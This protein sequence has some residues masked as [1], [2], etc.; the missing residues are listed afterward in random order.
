[1]RHYLSIVL[2]ALLAACAGPQGPSGPS[3]AQQQMNY[4]GPTC[5]PGEVVYNSPAILPIAITAVRETLAVMNEIG[6]RHRG[7]G[8]KPRADQ[9]AIMSATTDWIAQAAYAGQIETFEGHAYA[10]I[11]IH[12]VHPL[13]SQLPY[14]GGDNICRGMAQVTKIADGVYQVQIPLDGGEW[15]GRVGLAVPRAA[16]ITDHQR[17]WVCVGITGGYHLAYQPPL[18]EGPYKDEP[19][20]VCGLP[21]PDGGKTL[22]GVNAWTA[23]HAMYSFVVAQK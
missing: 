6:R 10:R 11:R 2:L 20:L 22:L 18:R 8:D 3:T 17:A 23:K 7:I 14:F 9:I 16:F 4:S 21:D 12:W 5:R 19:D 13:P 1:M 15:K